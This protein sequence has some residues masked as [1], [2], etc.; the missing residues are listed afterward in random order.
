MEDLKKFEAALD[1]K[2]AEQKAE[3]A[4]NT[5]KAAKAFESRIEQIN[6]ELVLL[7]AMVKVSITKWMPKL[8]KQ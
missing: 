4:V 7:V 8:Y 1:A 2:F 6:E 3:V 5:E